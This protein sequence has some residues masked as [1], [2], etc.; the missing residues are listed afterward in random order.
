MAQGAMTVAVQTD[1]SRYKRQR[2]RL[3]FWAIHGLP[4]KQKHQNNQKKQPEEKLT[5]IFSVPV[6]QRLLCKIELREPKFCN[7]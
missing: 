2:S 5:L 6:F 3:A 7:L 4:L 1:L